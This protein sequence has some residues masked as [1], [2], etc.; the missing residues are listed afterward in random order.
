MTTS[1]ENSG[2]VP[3]AVIWG[4][5]LLLTA[6]IAMTALSTAP[7]RGKVET[8]SGETSAVTHSRLFTASD[9][10]DGTVLVR[11]ATSGRVLEV[12]DRDS[13]GFIRGA[14]RGLARE[15]GMQGI[16]SGEPFRLR[17][18]E[19][20]TLVLDD[21]STG[22]LVALNAFGKDNAQAFAKYLQTETGERS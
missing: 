7:E 20:G 9:Q 14:L 2:Q 17:L 10:P 5:G 4:C 18:W 8:L 11:D 15:R 12:V 21:P 22:H 6:A 16:G 13:N 19:D 3:L 1:G